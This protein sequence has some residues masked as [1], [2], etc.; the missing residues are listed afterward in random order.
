MNAAIRA[1]CLRRARL[2]YIPAFAPVLIVVWL[3]WRGQTPAAAL[4]FCAVLATMMTGTLVPRCSLFGRMIKQMPQAGDQAL[5]TIDDGPHPQHTPAILDILDQHGIKA[6]FFLIGERAAKH[7]QLVREIVARGHEIGNHTQTHPA[8]IFWMLRPARI[9]R[10]IAGCQ[11]TLTAICPEQ[12]PRFF[13]PPAGHH[14]LCTAMIARTLGLRMML[15]SA[16][17]F[18]GVSRDLPSI[19][20]RIARRLQAGAIVLIHEGTPVAVEVAQAVAALMA[21]SGLNCGTPPESLAFGDDEVVVE[22]RAAP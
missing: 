18:D 14:N 4:L 5:L 15:W 7:P 2:R 11:E 6:L 16:R 8:A 9:W 21:A 19:T 1:S 20:Q 13:R 3:A 12:P 10:E 17:G 22:R